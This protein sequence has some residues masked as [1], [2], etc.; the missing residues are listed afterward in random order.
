MEFLYLCVRLV[1]ESSIRLNGPGAVLAG[2]Q[3]VIDDL[4]RRN[5]KSRGSADPWKIAMRVLKQANA[6]H[7]VKG[8]TVMTASTPTE[9]LACLGKQPLV[10]VSDKPTSTTG[11]VCGR[12]RRRKQARPQPAAV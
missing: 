10:L 1:L 11:R 8:A 3:R 12:Q 7:T 5:L 6:V 2:R 9:F 4:H